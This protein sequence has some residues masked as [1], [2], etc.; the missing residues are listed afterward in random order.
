MQEELKD[1]GKNKEFTNLIFPELKNAQVVDDF[2]GH[3]VFFFF[4]PIY[5]SKLYLRSRRLS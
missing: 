1:C 3:T 4:K 5:K 2:P